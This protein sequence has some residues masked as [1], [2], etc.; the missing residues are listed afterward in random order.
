MYL[1][2]WSDPL[3]D[4]EYNMQTTDSVDRRK[5]P[6]DDLIEKNLSMIYL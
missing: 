1:K 3:G 4:M 5:T 2:T 6:R